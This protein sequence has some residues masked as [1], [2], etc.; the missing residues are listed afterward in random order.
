LFTKISGYTQGTV[1]YELYRQRVHTLRKE[2]N[3]NAEEISS[4]STCRLAP[5]VL[6]AACVRV[7]VF[8][9]FSKRLSGL[10]CKCVTLMHDS[11]SECVGVKMK[12]CPCPS[13]RR[14]LGK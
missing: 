11:P 8:V 14:V 1:Q 12:V 2:S 5:H 10:L 4:L 13:L 9:W 3:E 6:S 7:C